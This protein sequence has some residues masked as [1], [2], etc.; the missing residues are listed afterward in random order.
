MLLSRQICLQ[1][2]LFREETKLISILEAIEKKPLSPI[3]KPIQFVN[4]SVAT[5][6]VKETL[7][8]GQLLERLLSH[9]LRTPNFS[10]FESTDSFAMLMALLESRP[11]PEFRPTWQEAMCRFAG[12]AQKGPL[13]NMSMMHLMRCLRHYARRQEELSPQ[14]DVVSWLLPEIFE[15]RRIR[16]ASDEMLVDLAEDVSQST[17]TSPVQQSEALASLHMVMEQTQRFKNLSETHA[18]KLEFLF[19]QF[20]PQLTIAGRQM[21]RSSASYSYESHF[22]A[23]DLE[24]QIGLADE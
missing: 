2:F 3:R 19:Q 21:P 10:L 15:E 1:R 12:I 16:S 24:R 20:A 4:A 22:I 23:R 11:L 14:T 7:L 9:I 13:F 17:R 6:R 8:H 5:N 18:E